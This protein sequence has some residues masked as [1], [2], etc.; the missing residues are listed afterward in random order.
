M[1]LSEGLIRISVGLD[2]DIRSAWETITACLE[3][4]D[5]GASDTVPVMGL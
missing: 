2:N 4:V 3:A 5:V 1:G